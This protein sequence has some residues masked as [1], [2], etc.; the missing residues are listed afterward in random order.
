MLTSLDLAVSERLEVEAKIL[1]LWP[2]PLEEGT[3]LHPGH[4]MQFLPCRVEGVDGRKLDLSLE[5]A[6]AHPPG[7]VVLLTHLDGDRLRVVGRAQL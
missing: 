4:W 2:R 3:V 7:S 1:D 6:L 5:K